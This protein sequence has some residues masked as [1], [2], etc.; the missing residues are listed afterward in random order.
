VFGHLRNEL[1][2]EIDLE[3]EIRREEPESADQATELRRLIIAACREWK[4]YRRYKFPAES[5]KDAEKWDYL[6]ED[7]AN[8]ILWEDGDYAM[9]AEFIDEEPE[10][11]RAKMAMMGIDPDYFVDIAPDPTDEE[12]E[13]IRRQSRGL[14]GRVTGNPEG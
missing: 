7:L 1:S 4:E 3:D 5:S 9:A 2:M 14:A 8:R 10:E 13:T 6:L 12:L 11:F